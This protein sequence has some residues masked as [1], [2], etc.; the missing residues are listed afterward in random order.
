MAKITIVGLG[1]GSAAQLTREAWEVLTGAGELWLRTA[2][3]PVTQGLPAGLA[4]HSF[5][6][7]YEERETFSEV[8]AEIVRQVL[9]LGRRAEGVVYA[10][11]GHP[12]VGES[13]APEILKAARAAG[14]PV[15]I[16]EGLSFIEPTLSALEVDA[17]DGLQLVDALDIAAEHHPQLNPDRPALIAQVYSRA[18]A[19][20]LKLTLMNQYPDEHKVVLVEAAGTAAQV[21]ET[22]PLYEI[23]RRDHGPLTSLYVPAMAPV[24]SFE[25]FQETVA[26]LRAPDG[27]PWDREQTHQTLRTNLLEEAYEVIQ[28]I[29]AEDEVAL[30]EELGDLLLQIVLHSQIA[31]DDGEFRMADVVAGIDAKIKRRHPHVWGDVAA[32]G[33]EQVLQNWEV[34]K[35]KERESSGE[36]EKSLLEGV[37][38]ALPALA[39]AYSYGGR[40]SRVGFDWDAI[41]GVWEKVQEELEELRAAETPKE[42]AEELGDLLFAV[43]NL[44]RWMKVDPESALRETNMKFARRF[45]YVESKA[46]ERGQ[47]LEKMGLAALDQLWDEAKAA[48][49]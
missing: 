23:D 35:R 21:V 9:E 29:D 7:L 24:H 31:V 41:A 49:L 22:M 13:T 16:V 2:R 5:D 8:Y 17:V 26:R 45:R 32:Q 15:R 34:L 37:P 12:L 27:C 42:Q 19:S 1:P 28:A 4:V 39:Q 10:V 38:K 36:A 11:P 43:V 18:V 3:H 33:A 40:A 48:G 46:R 30:C 44:A 6:G 25:G 14:I 20:D 47:A